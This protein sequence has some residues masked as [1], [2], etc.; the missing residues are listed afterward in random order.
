MVTGY[1]W[2]PHQLMHCNAREGM[3]VMGSDS[4]RGTSQRPS[5]HGSVHIHLALLN[6]AWGLLNRKVMLAKPMSFC[7]PREASAGYFY[8]SGCSTSKHD[9]ISTDAQPIQGWAAHPFIILIL[10]M[11]N[12]DT[13]RIHSHTHDYEDEAHHQLDCYTLAEQTTQSISFF[14]TAYRHR[15]VLLPPSPRSLI[16]SLKA[17]WRTTAW[18]NPW[19][20]DC[21]LPLISHFLLCSNIRK[22]MCFPSSVLVI[23]D[24]AQP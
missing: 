14:C 24:P 10:C 21:Q 16:T 1:I 9:L 18:S 19:K 5:P 23:L 2:Q 22:C 4:L 13:T 20:Q 7:S 8:R 15:G 17:V 3:E 6:L 11:L 12:K